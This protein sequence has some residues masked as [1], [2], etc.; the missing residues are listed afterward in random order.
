MDSNES[1]RFLTPAN[2]ILGNIQAKQLEIKAA[3]AC[4]IGNNQTTVD[5][6]TFTGVGTD[7][8][9]PVNGLFIDKSSQLFAKNMTLENA[10]LI[11]LGGASISNAN[12]NGGYVFNLG[13]L[14]STDF[15]RWKNI[16]YMY[17]AR[18]A[19]IVAPSITI[20]AN[21]LVNCGDVNTNEL[22][23]SVAASFDNRGTIR[24]NQK[25]DLSLFGEGTNRGEING[26]GGTFKVRGNKFN[27]EKGKIT[28]A[29]IKFKAEQSH[30]DGD[31]FGQ[32][33]FFRGT[34][35]ATGNFKSQY[36]ALHGGILSNQS[37][38]FIV[39]Q[40]LE[41][42]GNRAEIRN[43]GII[44]VFEIA[45][46]A[47]TGIISGGTVEAVK[48]HSHQHLQL[49]TRLPYLDS[50]VTD[51]NAELLIRNGSDT[52]ELAN[53]SNSGTTE[54]FT[55]NQKITK[56]NNSGSGNLHLE[57]STPLEVESL[58][59]LFGNVDLKASLPKLL[60][61][62]LQKYTNL[63]MLSGS[64]LDNL[65][66]V[67]V[68]KSA[69]FTLEKGVDNSIHE[70]SNFGTMVTNSP[71]M[72]LNAV[73]NAPQ[74]NMHF[75]ARAVIERCYF[76]KGKAAALASEG[77]IW[78][79][80]TLL[81]NE[82]NISVGKAQKYG[83]DNQNKARVIVKGTYKASEDAIF[84]IDRRGGITAD[85]INNDGIF[86]GPG[87]LL[88]KTDGGSTK[89]GRVVAEDGI[90]YEI[91]SFYGKLNPTLQPIIR[92]FNKN[93]TVNA[94][95]T[96]GVTA[97]INWNVDMEI[98]ADKFT[99]YSDLTVRSLKANVSGFDNSGTI[100][101]KNG[102]D[103][104]TGNFENTSGRLQSPRDININAT[105]TF[106]NTGGGTLQKNVKETITQYKYVSGRLVS[107]SIVFYRDVY[108]PN[109]GIAGTITSGGQLN[110]IADS[111]D[112]SFGILNGAFG[113]LID[114]N[115]AVSNE[116]GLI[117]S[118]GRTIIDA[119]SLINGYKQG[120]EVVEG[121]DPDSPIKEWQTVKYKEWVEEGHKKWSGGAFGKLSRKKRWVD[122]SHW[123]ERK[124][125]EYVT[126]GYEPLTQFTTASQYP[127][128]IFSK[129]N[130]DLRLDYSPIYIGTVV[131]GG[132]VMLRGGRIANINSADTGLVISYGDVTAELKRAAL[133]QLVIQAQN[134]YMNL[135]DDL[136][137]RGIIRPV[138]LPSGSSIQ[139]I[140][141][142]K[143][144]PQ[145][146]FLVDE[147]VFAESDIKERSPTGLVPMAGLGTGDSGKFSIYKSSDA[148]FMGKKPSSNFFMPTVQTDILRQ[149]I[150]FTLAPIYGRDIL[151]SVDLTGELMRNGAMF[152]GERSF[153]LS[154]DTPP[155]LLF[156][157]SN[158][159]DV[160]VKIDDQMVLVPL[161]DPFLL[162]STISRILNKIKA[163]ESINIKSL[164]NIRL[165][166][167]KFSLDSKKVA[168]Q[169]EKQIQ[170]AAEF[171]YSNDGNR[172]G[173]DPVS[174][175]LDGD[176]E[177]TAK[178]GIHTSGANLSAK[179]IIM[180]TTEGDITD[181]S[182]PLDPNYK[183]SGSKVVE[184]RQ[185]TVTSNI[186]AK[187]SVSMNA[188]KGE[189]SQE[190]TTISAKGDIK[191]SAKKHIVAPAYEE[192]GFYHSN[193]KG[194]SH[195]DIR[196][197][198]SGKIVSG[199]TVIFD[200][201]DTS[202]IGAEIIATA[203]S[204]P[205]DGT[206][207]VSPAFT[208]QKSEGC[209]IKNGFLSSSTRTVEEERKTIN[210]TKIMTR[211]FETLGKGLCT[212]ESVVMYVAE[213]FAEKALDEIAGYESY[214]M[215]SRDTSY[216]FFAPKIKGDPLV[217]SLKGV[218]NVVHF[219]GD[220]LPSLFNVV[221][222][223]AQTL[224]HG[225]TL[226]NL[227]SKQNPV[228]VLSSIFLSRFVA[229]FG[230]SKRETQISRKE[231]K[232]W[233]SRV[234]VGVL[235]VSN[236]RTH[237]EGI[238]DVNKARIDTK[239]FT[240]KAPEH[241]VEQ[242]A[243]TR[244]WSVSLSPAAVLGASLG[245]I[246][247]AVGF[248]PNVA[249]QK[250]DSKFKQRS[251]QPMVLTCDD[252]F[253]RCDDVVFSGSKIRS[254]LLEMIVTG[255]LKIETLLGEFLSESNSSAI[256]AS[257]GALYGAVKNIDSAPS[258]RDPRLGAV[259]RMRFASE[260]QLLRKVSA[261]AELVGTEKFYLKVGG[262]LHKVGATVGLK[263]DGVVV[264]SEAEK[265][266]A[267]R[268]LEE[269]IQECERHKKHV[270]NPA[271]GEFFAMMSQIDEFN[272]VRA[273]LRAEQ[274]NRKVS[275]AEQE[276]TDREVKQFLEKN[277]VKEKYAKIKETKARLDRVIQKIAEIEAKH[278]EVK[279]AT[280]QP[281]KIAA[282]PKLQPQNTLPAAKVNATRPR[283]NHVVFQPLV[284]EEAA[285]VQQVQISRELSQEPTPSVT[286]PA[287]EYARTIQEKKSLTK[288]LLDTGVSFKNDI[289]GYANE[290]K[291]TEYV[292]LGLESLLK[293][294]GYGA[295][296][297]VVSTTAVKF[298][299]IAA[300]A[301][302]G[303][304]IISGEAAAE[305]I[306]Y[307]GEKLVNYAA[308]FADTPEEAVKYADVVISSLETIVTIAGAVGGYKAGK[309]MGA[310]LAS[311]KA[312]YA[313]AKIK[314]TFTAKMPGKPE[315]VAGE[316]AAEQ[317]KIECSLSQGERHF[318]TG[319]RRLTTG[320]GKTEPLLERGEKPSARPTPKQSEIDDTLRLRKAGQIVEPQ[321]SFLNG[322]RCKWGTPGSIRVDSLVNGQAAHEI[323]NY[324][325]TSN[326]S[327]L[328]Q[329]IVEQALK[330]HKHLPEGTR[331]I[332]KIDAR[333]QICT[334]KMEKNIVSQILKKSENILK[335]TDIQIIRE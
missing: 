51:K 247:P 172:I 158:V 168:L 224:T 314:Q 315:A 213:F 177:L 261:L 110:I 183:F 241:T 239:E 282:Q 69:T 115:R 326:V 157:E 142:K 30:L 308:S 49:K 42:K 287:E 227:A 126:V 64:K 215:R 34:N 52:P 156:N 291:W 70:I 319:R 116:C 60:Q 164:G 87:K 173:I 47:N 46:Y 28:A 283:E 106:T 324:N 149:L 178:N 91:E 159:P 68:G 105:G 280:Q 19:K 266:E 38:N 33:V 153:I 281:M 257:L 5:S 95:G 202:L 335:D 223:T 96:V 208:E 29:H 86:Y 303:G 195:T 276:Q 112:N 290:H 179:R 176:L 216:G 193:S 301:T 310:K 166:P 329:N 118:G 76:N 100:S 187:E 218:K 57:S 332:F 4:L 234:K 132:N 192:S 262:L 231:T 259:P 74:A 268:V 22:N 244:G 233:Q 152:R 10:L 93:L 245:G 58:D 8:R 248:L 2:F 84:R 263:P 50:I 167:G 285:V 23:A 230:Y 182:M 256:S 307:S 273:Q 102:I 6:I 288:S 94:K 204:N 89:L 90:T 148:R 207:S 246:S 258:L 119:Y 15:G 284:A 37:S 226:M 255:D 169:S 279:T 81:L 185:K 222:A 103:I 286:T 41:L 232:P 188:P 250:A 242:E 194:Y 79:G 114:S 312:N 304:L 323:K 251:P 61:L 54:I 146:G 305:A 162:T 240:T 32:K 228:A 154:E 277:E 125:N 123:E 206:F 144:A 186:S 184:K 299:T 104:K 48:I 101:A 243:K 211:Y 330:H 298:G 225:L 294:V 260:E 205:K 20:D 254:R 189:I 289:D 306:N 264:R 150:T 127:G 309:A 197:P 249:V 109:L 201:S 98:N 165:E 271:V 252:L 333:G 113:V 143:L 200:S 39:D 269:K 18:Q 138:F 137:I 139:I 272:Q 327:G 85:D 313:P 219:S 136:L 171:K 77:K 88:C 99:S 53:I 145:L 140:D 275:A 229:D 36:A 292:K 238:W 235:V 322:K 318:F 25:C 78:N 253:I 31:V 26:N 13:Q 221:G 9:N 65:N 44:D 321:V 160:E 24:T 111:F 267:G 220:T 151:L 11:N 72:K 325:L 214:K 131:S 107:S 293:G 45:S 82:G 59:N 196:V 181:K 212:L 35:I 56:I 71:L 295:A 66:E 300:V 62:N 198:K 3:T 316:T 334:P 237:L 7:N 296:I 75:Q 317:V 274:V 108:K 163:E 175:K 27:H 63:T 16:N 320:A 297:G 190:G 155:A 120:S 331:Q 180:E 141:L 17:N 12:L 117:Y 217:E 73:Y 1:V 67:E 302:A 128:Y 174:V 209:I 55:T 199:G 92:G 129:G 170:I 80:S 311:L 191:F 40:L 265:I 278:P 270:F 122:T 203:V 83:A 97:P 133:S 21:H 124:R 135:V 328:I 130:L 161:Y 147:S 14:G 236:D 43:K 210:P 134:I 121:V